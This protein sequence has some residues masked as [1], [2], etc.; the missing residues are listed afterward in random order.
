MIEY[1][2][3]LS[4]SKKAHHGLIQMGQTARRLSLGFES[5]FVA[6]HFFVK[7]YILDFCLF[8]TLSR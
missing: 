3:G 8:P 5:V 7:G 1:A 6:L 4:K 2:D